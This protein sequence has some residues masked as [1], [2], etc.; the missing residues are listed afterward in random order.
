MFERYTKD[1]IMLSISSLS[2][3]NLNSKKTEECFGESGE[4]QSYLMFCHTYYG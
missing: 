3:K 4:G 1:I 2:K